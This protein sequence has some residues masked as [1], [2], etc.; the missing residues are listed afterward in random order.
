M[1]KQTVQSR[2]VHF[3]STMH[4]ST[5]LVPRLR[6]TEECPS[7]IYNPS[8]LSFF[9]PF[10]GNLSL[11]LSCARALSVSLVNR[12]GGNRQEK[13]EK[14]RRDRVSGS[15]LERKRKEKDEEEAHSVRETGCG[16]LFTSWRMIPRGVLLQNESSSGSTG[17]GSRGFQ[18]RVLLNLNR[19]KGSRWKKFSFERNRRSWTWIA[20][21]SCYFAGWKGIFV[22]DLPR[23]YNKSEQGIVNYLYAFR[24]EFY[25][26]DKY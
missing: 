9:I 15:C 26:R 6:S 21:L 11:S 13:R 17:K 22:M 20:S 10:S 12:A 19:D 24:T 8:F 1:G 23:E 16:Q 5:I 14:K 3:M 4:L 25:I 2:A 7:S 18:V